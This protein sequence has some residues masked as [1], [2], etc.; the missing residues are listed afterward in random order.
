M[1]QR[2][3]A[4]R[5]H[6]YR[7]VEDHLGHA[8]E[9][10]EVHLL[11]TERYLSLVWPDRDGSRLLTPPDEP[12]TLGDV[13]KRL[14]LNDWT[15]ELLSEDMGLP[16]EEHDPDRFTKARYIDGLFD[17]TRFDTLILAPITAEEEAQSP[18]GNFYIYDGKHRALVLAKRLVA[19]EETYRK[20]PALL[21]IPRPA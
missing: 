17:Y 4:D 19:D 21:M 7:K 12:R 6:L 18:A 5:H 2:I 14:L 16:I 15:F 3:K 10:Y 8:R 13:A 11:D 20:V 1:I 9:L